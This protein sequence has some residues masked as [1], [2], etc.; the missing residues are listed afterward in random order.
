VKL[1]GVIVGRI[2]FNGGFQYIPKGQDIGG[3]IFRKLSECKKS[4]KNEENLNDT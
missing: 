4:L 1:N 3:K 2:I